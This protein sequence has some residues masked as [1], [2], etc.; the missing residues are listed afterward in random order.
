MQPYFFL[1]II[2]SGLIHHSPIISSNLKKGKSLCVS[3]KWWGRGA[4][5]RK[6]GVKGRRG[7][8]GTLAS[9][10]A[11]FCL[12]K[13]SFPRC[14]LIDYFLLKF[15][16]D[17][18]GQFLTEYCFLIHSK[19]NPEVGLFSQPTTYISFPKHLL[20]VLWG[21]L[22]SAQTHIQHL[23]CTRTALSTS[24]YS[25]NLILEPI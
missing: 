25:S 6:R 12:T 14:Q 15:S 8:L 22:C 18:N 4:I 13:S 23:P 17:T 7:S 10:E 5:S 1:Q 2:L 9:Q 20:I 16:T 21:M 19:R 3:W 24:T 11:V